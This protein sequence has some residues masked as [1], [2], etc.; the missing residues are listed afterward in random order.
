M[1][2][3]NVRFFLLILFIAALGWL[4]PAMDPAAARAEPASS[5]MAATGSGAEAATPSPDSAL[6]AQPTTTTA[7]SA[8]PGARARRPARIDLSMPYY[9]F[10]RLPIPL[11][12]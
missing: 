11:R 2:T 5:E 1:T 3:L 10:G 7:D 6:T 4:A 8:V 12:D 9:R